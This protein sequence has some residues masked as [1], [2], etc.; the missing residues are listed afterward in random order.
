ML[1]F[2]YGSNTSPARLNSPERLLGAATPLGAVE[3]ADPYEL[4]FTV[5]SDGNQCAAADLVAGAGRRIWGV[6]Y[7]I[8]DHLITRESARGRRSMDQ[9]EGPRYNRVP[10]ALLDPAGLAGGRP[11]FTYLVREPRQGLRTS[12]AYARHILAGL[13]EFHVPEDYL[14]Y[15]RDRIRLNNPTL[16]AIAA[17]DPIDFVL[18][19]ALEEERDALLA[20]LPGHRKVEPDGHD[21]HVYYR[22]EVTTSRQDGGRYQI[23]VST[24]AGMGPLRAVSKAKDVVARWTPSH[25]LLVGIAGGVAG[26]ADPGDVLVASQVADYTLGKQREDGTRGVRWEA[27]R[28][29]EVLLNAASNFPTGWEELIGKGR[30]GAGAPVRRVGVVASGGDVIARVDLIRE[31]QATWEKLVGVEMEGGG[32]ASG[33]HETV[34]RPRFLMIRGISDIA[35]G[36]NNSEMKT[37]WRAYACDVAAAYTV[38]LLRDGPVPPSGT[39]RLADPSLAVQQLRDYSARTLQTVATRSAIRLNQELIRVQRPVTTELLQ[40]VEGRVGRQEELTP[41]RH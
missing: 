2:Q 4:S 7:D 9:I 11:T 35:D 34:S 25:V 19:T 22:A 23:V 38:G 10:I 8:P 3:T 27:F 24:L 18:L 31:Y 16:A 21:V 12:S 29:D 36:P 5:W 14:A 37:A 39:S 15:V 30:P 20:K 6:L 13:Q 33:L 17:D 1:I 40:R 32:V 26:E 41:L 28:A